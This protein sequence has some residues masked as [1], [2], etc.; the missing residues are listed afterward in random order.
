MAM[1][2]Q[3][4]TM[5]I[6]AGT[7]VTTPSE[8]TATVKVKAFEFTVAAYSDFSCQACTCRLIQITSTHDNFVEVYHHNA[9]H[10]DYTSD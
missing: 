1:Q 7:G 5:V 4:V 8:Y 2:S 6:D 10:I 9:R 3:A